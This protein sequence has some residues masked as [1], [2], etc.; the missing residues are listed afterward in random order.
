MQ[1]ARDVQSC[2]NTRVMESASNSTKSLMCIIRQIEI[3]DQ[4]CR[5]EW[6]LPSS[7][8]SIS[9]NLL[10]RSIK[11]IGPCEPKMVLSLRNSNILSSSLRQDIRYLRYS[12]RLTYKIKYHYP[13]A[14]FLL[15]LPLRKAEEI[16]RFWYHWG[17]LLQNQ[18]WAFFL[19]ADSR[20]RSVSSREE[21]TREKIF[22]E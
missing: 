4:K 18:G 17:V 3:V 12:F 8:W 21:K 9:E 6:Y 5:L 20:L 13:T 1:K 11:I 7:L 19:E 10:P 16:H 14:R 15:S 2:E 22:R